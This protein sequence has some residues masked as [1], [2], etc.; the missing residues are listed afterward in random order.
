M[1]RLEPNLKGITT[2][3]MIGMFVAVSTELGLCYDGDHDGISDSFEE[4]LA[5]KFLPTMWFDEEENTEN[6]GT[7]IYRVRPHPADPQ[8]IAITYVV[9]YY[10][11]GG[12]F[13][14]D[15]HLGDNESFSLALTPNPFAPLGY[16]LFSIRAVAHWGVDGFEHISTQ[17]PARWDAGYQYNR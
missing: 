7:I 17:Y 6:P 16:T 13:W 10:C 5:E 8:D 9:L 12:D 2:L 3:L 14:A 4:E 15:G 1:A 11:D